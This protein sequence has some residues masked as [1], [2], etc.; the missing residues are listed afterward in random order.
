MRA[1]WPA[2]FI[3]L[4]LITTGQFLV[5]QT[6]CADPMVYFSV[7]AIKCRITA[8]WRGRSGGWQVIPPL[9]KYAECENVRRDL[10]RSLFKSDVST[11]FSIQSVVQAK[12]SRGL[13][14]GPVV[15][16]NNRVLSTLARL[17]VRPSQDHSWQSLVVTNLYGVY[18]FMSSCV[19]DSL[20]FRCK[21]F[22]V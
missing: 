14:L 1:T 4:D 2:H 7:S 17:Q 12:A 20:S 13:R 15:T 3:L 19:A 9:M 21:S 6:R 11:A 5:E 8:E 22:I 10:G 18:C 16:R